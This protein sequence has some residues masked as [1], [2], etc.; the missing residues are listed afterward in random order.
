MKTEY[1]Y[2]TANRRILQDTAD[3]LGEY[4]TAAVGAGWELVGPPVVSIAIDAIGMPVVVM[5]QM[6][7]KRGP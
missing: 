4:A 1:R 2:L 7:V 3:A 6:M 5:V